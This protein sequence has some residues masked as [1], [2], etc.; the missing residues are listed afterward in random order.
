MLGEFPDVNYVGIVKEVAGVGKV[1]SDEELGVQD[2]QRTYMKGYPVYLD[3]QQLFYEYLGNKSVLSQ[4]LSTWNPFKLYAD[5]KTV[6]TR[7]V[8]SE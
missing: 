5:F 6:S 8:S 3:E 2:F 1:K 7:L 4:P